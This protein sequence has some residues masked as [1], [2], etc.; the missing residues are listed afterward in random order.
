MTDGGDFSLPG[1]GMAIWGYGLMNEK[2]NFKKKDW[3][4]NDYFNFLP[5][6]L[7]E[8]KNRKKRLPDKPEWFFKAV[9]SRDFFG[10]FVGKELCS[11]QW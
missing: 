6:Q 10:V 2:V 5:Q 9:S 4:T 1:K 3:A 11:S 8:L 7:K